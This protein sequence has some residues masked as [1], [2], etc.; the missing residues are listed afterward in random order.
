MPHKNW[1]K[2]YKERTVVLNMRKCAKVQQFI[3]KSFPLC[4]FAPGPSQNSLTVFL[5]CIASKTVVP[6]RTLHP[7]TERSPS[8]GQLC[9][10]FPRYVQRNCNPKNRALAR[11]PAQLVVAIWI[12]EPVV[13][14][15]R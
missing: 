14:V 15:P 12:R 4:G 1:I 7:G 5:P 11:N 13:V 6:F 2:K 3:G 10:L 9:P 8:S